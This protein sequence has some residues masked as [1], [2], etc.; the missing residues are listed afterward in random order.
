MYLV[1]FLKIGLKFS[2]LLKLLKTQNLK[3]IFEITILI[4]YFL[5]KTIQVKKF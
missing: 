2:K 3:Q 4:A 1:W 5:E